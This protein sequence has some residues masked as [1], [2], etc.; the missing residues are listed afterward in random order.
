MV[1]G[2]P[3]LPGRRMSVASFYDMLSLNWWGST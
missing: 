3:G 1:V 2:Y